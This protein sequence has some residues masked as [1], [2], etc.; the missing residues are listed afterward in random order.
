ME[1]RR[2]INMAKGVRQNPLLASLSLVA[3][4][5]A[6]ASA[7]SP[8]RVI[9]TNDDLPMFLPNT[10]T[11][12]NV[13]PDGSITS[14]G[15]LNTL[16]YGNA[17]GYFSTSRIKVIRDGASDCAFVSNAWSGDVS[18]ISLSDRKVL[19]TF[20]GAD[21]DLGPDNGISLVLNDDHSYLY[22]GY[23]TSNTIG[24]FSVEPGCALT[25]VGSIVATGKNG[26]WPSAMA[27]GGARRLVVCVVG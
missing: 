16:G 10:I 19:G 25:Y 5:F 18:G 26:G 8:T 20:R 27:V 9:V 2:T 22:A 23:T 4:A 6:F 3:F 21:T 17:G 11:V 7:Q 1:R 14:Q 24:T 13:A 12:Y 15:K